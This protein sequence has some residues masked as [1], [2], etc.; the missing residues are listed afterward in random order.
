MPRLEEQSVK[1][2][3]LTEGFYN[4]LLVPL[5]DLEQGC[6][7]WLVCTTRESY[8]EFLEIFTYIPHLFELWP[9]EIRHRVQKKKE[10]RKKKTLLN[11]NQNYLWWVDLFP[12]V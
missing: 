1:L 7:S 10:E 2:K 4:E 3:F 9:F 8:L 12:F 5:Q 11:E 6:S